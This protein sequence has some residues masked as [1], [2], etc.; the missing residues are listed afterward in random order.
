MQCC[1]HVSKSQFQEKNPVLPIEKFPFLAPARITIML[2]HP[3]IHFRSIICQ[4]VA[5]GRLKRKENF[6][7]KTPYQE[8]GLNIDDNGL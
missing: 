1:I 4:V 5:Y 6:T 3:I 2:Q 8:N 7:P